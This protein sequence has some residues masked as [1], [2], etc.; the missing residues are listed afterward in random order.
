MAHHRGSSTP[1]WW[2]WTETLQLEMM[3][4]PAHNWVIDVFSLPL[5]SDIDLNLIK[6][7]EYWVR[8]GPLG[9]CLGTVN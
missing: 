1:W 8:R 2:L 7:T 4:K 5:S 9:Q 6:G 3:L